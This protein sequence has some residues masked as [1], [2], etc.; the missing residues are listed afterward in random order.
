MA[1]H[2]HTW[3]EILLEI[4]VL[5]T[6][7]EI[8]EMRAASEEGGWEKSHTLP[9]GVEVWKTDRWHFAL[10]VMAEDANEADALFSEFPLYREFYE[11]EKE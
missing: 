11:Q 6:E 1:K 8:A 2:L 5:T 7:R 9:N 10:E 4:Q 3:D